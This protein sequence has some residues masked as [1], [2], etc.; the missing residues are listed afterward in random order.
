VTYTTLSSSGHVEEA[1]HTSQTGD[2]TEA[3]IIRKEGKLKLIAI[4]RE[5]SELVTFLSV[6]RQSPCG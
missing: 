2:E 5:L 1:A 3:S 6:A 4:H